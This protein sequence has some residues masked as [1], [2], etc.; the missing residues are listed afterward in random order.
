MVLGLGSILPDSVALS[1]SV[2]Q[3]TYAPIEH[4]K[5]RHRLS[6]A[7]NELISPVV[8][9]QIR[10]FIGNIN[11]IP[12]PTR[13]VTAVKKSGSKRPMEAV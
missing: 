7:V 8:S 5:N 6:K 1:L 9:R 12:S 13:C 2:K 4:Q 11:H 3:N 10:R